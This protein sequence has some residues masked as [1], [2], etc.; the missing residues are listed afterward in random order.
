MNAIDSHSSLLAALQ[1]RLAPSRASSGRRGPGEDGRSA[2]AGQVAGTL[3]QRLAAMDRADPE[4]RRKAVRIVLEAQFAR[5]FGA[6]LL[7]DPAF[8]GLLEAVQG[9]LERDAQT[10]AAVQALGEHLL[11]HAS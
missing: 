9:Q 10:A 8:P 7:N 4:G 2:P 1:A 11:P 5:E 6:G 3:V